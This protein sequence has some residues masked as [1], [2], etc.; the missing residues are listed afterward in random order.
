MRTGRVIGY[1]QAL[2][3]LLHSALIGSLFSDD[4]NIDQ[5]LT[6]AYENY[7]LG[8]RANT[9]QERSLY[10]NQALE[11]YNTLETPRASHRLLSNIGS[12][13]FQLEE[14]PMAI[15]YYRKAL[16]LNPDDEKSIHDLE[17]ARKEAGVKETNTKTFFFNSN[18]LST[19]LF[20]G[21][22]VVL[23]IASLYIWVGSSV[24]RRGVRWGGAGCAVLLGILLYTYYFE[25]IHAIVV[26]SSFLHEDAGTHYATVGGEPL[27]G[28]MEIEVLN[29][30][31]G[32]EW[33][34]VKT[35]E[36]TEGYIPV[37]AI[38]LIN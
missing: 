2:L 10:F 31:G 25:P 12:C 28:G 19:W 15:L 17:F 6:R 23:A 8:E 22:G 34:L 16:Q 18:Q 9:Y 4:T 26:E 29:S 13:Y 24:L 30:A 3:I 11:I 5:E 38:R 21:S 1:V 35:K 20:W 37:K 7:R 27:I 36:G 32:M 14:F 33:Y